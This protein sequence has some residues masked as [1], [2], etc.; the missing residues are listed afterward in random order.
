MWAILGVILAIVIV[1][2]YF[3][4]DMNSKQAEAVIEAEV[5]IEQQV[6][7][8]GMRV[9]SACAAQTV[10]GVYTT[11]TLMGASFPATTPA[12]PGFLCIVR[13]GG[14]APN[15]MMALM[16]LDGVATRLGG[17]A[18][19]GATPEVLQQGL[20]FAVAAIWRSQVSGAS[21]MTTSPY[22][23]AMAGVVLK[24]SATPEMQAISS[25]NASASLDGFLQANFPY[26]TPA[27]TAG[28]FTSSW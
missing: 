11:P 2:Q 10:P 9:F 28:F 20:S 14:T 18:G 24:G 26:T 1:A 27:I 7:T 3:L 16:V 12:G 13:S 17:K 21:G 15:G 25:G 19:S 4:A 23:D 22:P 6:A 8:Q 5:S